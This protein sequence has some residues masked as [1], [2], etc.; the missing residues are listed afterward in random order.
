MGRSELVRQLQTARVRFCG[1]GTRQAK[2]RLNRAATRD[3]L[4]EAFR[5]ALEIEDCS[6][7]GKKY[8][9]D[10]SSHHYRIKTDLIHDLIEIAELNRW[11]YGSHKADTNFPSHIVYFDLP[12]CEQI[13][14]HTNLKSEIP[15]Y[16]KE[17]D[18]KRSATLAKLEVA[19]GKYLRGEIS[20]SALQASP[21]PL[22]G[23]NLD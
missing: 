1:I 2:L 20:G 14:F 6:I 11:P 4:A 9:G 10:W 21:Y 22:F 18:G 12:G 8:R 19:I 3:V 7:R 15:V 17:W 23:N 5:I 13:S 16:P